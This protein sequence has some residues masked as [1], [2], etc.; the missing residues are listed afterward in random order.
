MLQPQW[1]A[2]LSAER[3]SRLSDDGTVGESGG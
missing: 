1:L 2:D 3:R